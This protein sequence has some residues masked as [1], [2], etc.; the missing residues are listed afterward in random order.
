MEAIFKIYKVELK[1]EIEDI[2]DFEIY[3]G[4]TCDLTEGYPEDDN[5]LIYSSKS[6]KD[7]LNE[8]NKYETHYEILE[9]N[10]GS[11][12][13][14]I[15]EYYIEEIYDLEENGEIWH[16]SKIKEST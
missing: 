16:F 2:K 8:L 12:D 14:Y 13:V 9:N 10:N 4:I 11:C 6:F 15:T 5:E 3:E 1:Y 7:T